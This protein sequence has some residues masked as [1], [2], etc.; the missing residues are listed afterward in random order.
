[1]P[2]TIA[3]SLGLIV[4]AVILYIIAMYN[5]YKQLEVEVNQTLSS[6]ETYL[7]ERFDT[8][9]KMAKS[10]KQETDAE[11]D[12]LNE[13][14]KVRAGMT[15]AGTH[16]ER[17][18]AYKEANHSMNKLAIQVE[19][20]P[21]T[22][23]NEGFRQLQRSIVTI[24]DKLSAARR[25]YNAQVARFNKKVVTFPESIIAKKMNLEPKEFFT[26]SDMKRTDVDLDDIVN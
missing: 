13:L 11:S 22:Q 21:Q 9:T 25:A 23:F 19:N 1:M 17:I 7:E 2:T 18:D 6:V 24:E 4:L 8:L 12:L 26:V 16:K 5:H 3:I 14:T 20:Y 10:V 15:T